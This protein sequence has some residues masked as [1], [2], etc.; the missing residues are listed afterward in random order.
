MYCYRR[1]GAVIHSCD[2]VVYRHAQNRNGIEFRG[3]CTCDHRGMLDEIQ[4]LRAR[5]KIA[6]STNVRLT[7]QSDCE[8]D[9]CKR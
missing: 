2:C 1:H 7:R 4:S 9:V 6:H 5:I 8:C 3:L